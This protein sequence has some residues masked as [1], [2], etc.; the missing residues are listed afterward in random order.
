[1]IIM[2][3]EYLAGFLHIDKAAT[4]TYRNTPDGRLLTVIQHSLLVILLLLC[5][6]ASVMIF[7]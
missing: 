4:K 2:M 7:S 6:L 1:M 5:G 3:I